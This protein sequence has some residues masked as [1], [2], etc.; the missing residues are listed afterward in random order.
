M[1]PISFR[2]E[3]WHG[4]IQVSVTRRTASKIGDPL[5]HVAAMDVYL[6][7]VFNIEDSLSC[8]KCTYKESCIQVE[9]SPLA[10]IRENS[11]NWSDM[12]WPSVQN[13]E[14]KSFQ[15]KKKERAM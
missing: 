6:Q 11:R 7:K 2:T 4:S 8:E 3:S 9:D 13:D 15:Q 10:S 14:E 5:M 1:D 12:T